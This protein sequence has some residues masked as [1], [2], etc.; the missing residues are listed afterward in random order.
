MW[1]LCVV[2]CITHAMTP[3]YLPFVGPTALAIA[4]L[5]DEQEFSSVLAH[6][7][8]SADIARGQSFQALNDALKTT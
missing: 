3:L 5:S 2:S 4:R 6:V 8:G 1:N 7:A